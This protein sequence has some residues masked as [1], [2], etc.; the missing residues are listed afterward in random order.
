MVIGNYQQWRAAARDLLQRGVTPQNASWRCADDAQERLFDGDGDPASGELHRVLIPRRFLALA[1]T[2]ALHADLTRWDLLYR[3]LWRLTHGEPHLLELETDPDV[4][5]LLS[6]RH[7]VARDI[8]H[9]QAYVRFRKVES[10]AGE[11]FVAWYKPAHHILEVNGR[12]F[13]ERFGSMQWAILT[14]RASLVWDLEK[15][16]LGP[17]VPRSAAPREDELE[18]LWRLYYGTIFNPARLKLTAMRAHMPV[19]R[20]VDLPETR[21]LAEMVRTSQSRVQQMAAAQPK[22]AAELIPTDASLPVLRESIARCAA[23]PLCGLANGPVVGEGSA[24]A[25]IV[26]VGEQPGDEEDLARR[27]FVGPAGQVLNQA[28]VEAGLD[29][30]ELYLT[31][32]VKAFKYEPRGKRRLHQNPRPGEVSV[33]RPWLQAEL[34]ALRPPVIVCLGATA[35]LSV[36]G[37]KVQVNHERGQPQPH[38]GSIVLLTFHPSALLRTP[39][40]EKKQEMFAL[41]VR[42]LAHAKAIAD[43][44]RN[45]IVAGSAILPE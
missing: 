40:P 13:V 23:C 2:A 25:S 33:C 4:S 42:D 7:A 17:G 35:G 19:S 14:P 24:S 21:A 3:V 26:L 39:D 10:E 44:R 30:S 18:D 11:R 45:A 31:N 36:L 16:E 27:P 8:H 32:A 43:Q 1:E 9:M 15:L 38:A 37:R 5:T 12:F 20:W 29:R 34:E 22:T 28:L 41:L 6:M